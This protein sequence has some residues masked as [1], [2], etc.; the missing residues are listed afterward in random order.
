VE[1]LRADA[2]ENGTALEARNGCKSLLTLATF[3]GRTRQSSHS[4]PKAIIVT[5]VIIVGAAIL[6]TMLSIAVTMLSIAAFARV[7]IWSD[8]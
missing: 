8:Y 7:G 2:A 6:M 5:T 3:L 1:A 4:D